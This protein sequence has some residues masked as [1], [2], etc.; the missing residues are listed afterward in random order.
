M[1]IGKKFRKILY[2]NLSFEKYLRTLSRLYFFSY[3]SGLLRNNPGIR[4][5]YFLKNII[6]KGDVVIDIGANLGYYTCLFAR[7]V[8]KTGKVYAIEPVEPV[9]NVLQ[10]NAKKY[11][12]VEILPYALGQENK[13]IQLGNDSLKSHGYVASGSHFVMDAPNNPEAVENP[14][15]TFYAV[16]RKGSELFANLDRIDFIK[17]DV[18]GYETVIIPEIQDV[19]KQFHPTLL[20]ETGHENRP[21]IISIMTDMGYEAMVLEHNKLRLQRPEDSDDI[22]FVHPD[23]MTS[24]EPYFYP[25]N[26]TI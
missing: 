21:K 14:E 11:P 15:I 24:V 25:K 1:N 12:C 18:E 2:K 17:C 10:K 23:R 20:I 13:T 22:L 19:I 16:M 9:R 3:R 5:P 26:Q 6:K 4:Y 8:G 7:W